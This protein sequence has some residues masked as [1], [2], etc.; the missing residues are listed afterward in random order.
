[1]QEPSQKIKG[2]DEGWGKQ[3]SRAGTWIYSIKEQ[4]FEVTRISISVVT[5]SL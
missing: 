1:M 4:W 3:S 5:K 2:A